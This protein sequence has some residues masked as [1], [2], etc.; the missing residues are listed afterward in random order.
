MVLKVQGKV[1]FMHVCLASCVRGYPDAPPQELINS[2][3][4]SEIEE[5]RFLYLSRFLSECVS[6]YI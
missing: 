3:F 2:G 1:I 6:L 5:R 4:Q